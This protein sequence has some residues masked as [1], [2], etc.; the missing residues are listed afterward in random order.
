MLNWLARYAFVSAELAFDERGRL[1]ESVLDVGCGPHGLSIV[2]PDATFV[3]IDVLFPGRV[4]DGMVALRSEPGPFPFEDASFDTVVCLDVL[5]HVP[6][7]DRAGFVTELAR[8]A[9][10][11]VLLACP[12]DE[13]AWID[14]MFRRIFAA[15]GG[16]APEWLNEHDQYGLPTVAEI[17]AFC[18]APEGFHA[19][20]L[21][22]SNGLLSTLAVVADV[23]L[24][25]LAAAEFGHQRE[26]WIEL[27][28]TGRFG[29]CP[30][31]G[32]AIERAAAEV[33]LVDP[34]QLPGALMGALRCPA[35]GAARVRH[36]RV[37]ATCEACGHKLELDPSGALSL[38][39]PVRPAAPEPVVPSPAAKQ[40]DGR[41]DAP[42][43]RPAQPGSGPAPAPIQTTA[44]TRLLLARDW[45]RP[46]EWLPALASYVT[47]APA[48]GDTALCL[49]ASDT[50]V[51]LAVVAEMLTVACETLSLGRPFADVVVLDSPYDRDGLIPVSDQRELNAALGLP[52]ASPPDSDE[53]ILNHAIVTKSLLDALSAIL[54]RWRFA[55]AADPW[56][57]REPLV[58]VRI[59]TWGQHELLLSRAI[60]SVLSGDYANVEI[61]VCSDGQDPA[62]RAAVE[63]LADPRVRYLDLPERPVYPQQPWNFWRAAGSHAVNRALGEC[64]GSFIAPL[65]HDDAFTRDHIR[66][67]LEAAYQQR[68]DFVYGKA[69]MEEPD[70]SWVLLGSAPLAVGQITH[71]SVLYSSRLGHMRLDPAAWLLNEPAD[72]NM[73]RR[74]QALGSQVAF[75]PEVVFV[76]FRERTSIELDDDRGSSLR[77]IPRT[78][79]EMVADLRRTGLDWLLDVPLPERVA[80]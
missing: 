26:G 12:S 62:A 38:A 44:T 72:W 76:H 3:G 42:A 80:A 27:F 33:A 7:E 19:R 31:K 4:A 1:L 51:P 61:V 66:R 54:D 15:R 23:E 29:D 55:I 57:E 78:P 58:S 32:W 73:W 70:G 79:A 16:P 56:R 49:D 9:A 64:R 34:G 2:A 47:R 6:G 11:R 45:E 67:L 75:L 52:A 63:G 28:K 36:E 24:S 71:G 21:T 65:D 43:P 46:L 40:Q 8:V 39:P 41:G 35:C 30:R 50:E 20:E 37:A 5:E 18:S 69:L 68:A 60:P 77:Q 13:G 10:R 22:M 53:Q 74:I 48:D 17:A 25:N 14:D 59:A